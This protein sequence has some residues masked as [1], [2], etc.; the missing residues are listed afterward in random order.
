MMPTNISIIIATRNRERILWETVAKACD[1]IANKNAEIII[2]NDGDTAL[3]VPTRLQTGV[4]H[5]SNPKKGVSSARNFGVQQASGN[6]LF[7]IDDDMWISGASI[8]W[9]NT[10]F[11]EEENTRSVYFINWEY[12]PE[13]NDRLKQSKV[14]RYIVGADYNRL[15]GKMHQQ[16]TQPAAG[17]YKYDKLGS[18]SLVM[19]KAVFNKAGGYNEAIIFAGEDDDLA[20]KFNRSG[21]PI[22]VVFDITLHHNHQDRLEINSFLKRIY[23]GAGSEY[24]ALKSGN[25]NQPGKTKY[26]GVNLLLFDLFCVTE[27]G[28]ILLHRL[29]PNLAFLQPLQN[30]LIGILGGLQKYK[31]WKKVIAGQTKVFGFYKL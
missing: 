24:R 3:T 23:D 28:W 7:F 17:L 21:I 11:A 1:A 8:D 15:W 5:F 22:Y 9:I 25:F 27:K 12:P 19:S 10:R 14:G 13:L 31:Q 26:K 20:N 29:L 6:I 16:A 4:R 30:R 2:I 18:C